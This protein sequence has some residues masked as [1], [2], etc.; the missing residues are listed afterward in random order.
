MLV[1]FFLIL[2]KVA[3]QLRAFVFAGIPATVPATPTGPRT[4]RSGRELLSLSVQA[5][6]MAPATG[7]PTRPVTSPADMGPPPTRPSNPGPSDA[8]AL[9]SLT[10]QVQ[11]LTA[12]NAASQQQ[13]QQMYMAHQTVQQ[14]MQQLLAHLNPP[15]HPPAHSTAPP[16]PPPALPTMALPGLPPGPVPGGHT[17]LATSASPGTPPLV[18]NVLGRSLASYFPDVKP[19]LLLAITKH[20]LDPGQLFKIDPQMKDRPKDAQL[21][22]SDA[23]VLIKAE[24]DGS[25]KEYPSFRSLHDPPPHLFQ[26]HHAPAHRV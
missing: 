2:S 20:E 9:A 14:Q 6:P 7:S 8:T 3:T 1:I 19:A 4:L 5:E 11:Q 22:L 23:G 18:P 10:S 17:G 24:R 26:H 15:A 25:P 21:Q 13:M 12:N 16:Q